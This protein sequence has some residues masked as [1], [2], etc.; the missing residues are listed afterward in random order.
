MLL[1]VLWTK[2]FC[3]K[4]SV[5]LKERRVKKGT[6]NRRPA[7]R[8]DA[9]GYSMRWRGRC[10]C[11]EHYILKRRAGWEKSEKQGLEGC[12]GRD[13]NELG[14]KETSPSFENVYE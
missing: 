10:V 11:V 7:N 12:S 9:L 5:D 4:E 3:V 13:C 8:S 14:I 1:R 6:K 2:A